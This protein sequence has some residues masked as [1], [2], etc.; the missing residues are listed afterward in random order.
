MY[1]ELDKLKG[2]AKYQLYIVTLHAIYLCCAYD[3][4]PSMRS[5]LLM[6][7]ADMVGYI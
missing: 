4:A 2:E 1:T 7:V 3:L 5:G 6:L